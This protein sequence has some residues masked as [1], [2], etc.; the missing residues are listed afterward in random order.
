MQKIHY[1]QIN[2][3]KL[4][5]LAL[6]SVMLSF[7]SC[8]YH[9]SNPNNSEVYSNSYSYTIYV[10]D[11]IPVEFDPGH[12]YYSINIPAITSYIV[13]NGAVLVYYRNNDNNWVLLPYSTTFYNQYN[14][15]YTEE[16]WSG[17]S[18]GRLDIDYVYTN[19]LDLNPRRLDIKVLII[20]F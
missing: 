14:E 17:F 1:P 5:R 19:K 6:F 15:P 9:E 11:W 13:N 3:P 7:I 20:G 2:A 10:N 8:T 12:W 4:L 16:I 18:R